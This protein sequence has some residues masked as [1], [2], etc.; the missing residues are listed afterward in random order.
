MV[1]VMPDITILDYQ[2]GNL[3]SIAMAVKYCGGKP[4]I[5]NNPSEIAGA[6][7]LILAGVGAFGDAIETLRKSHLSEAI[8]EFINRGR[9][10]LG[11]C[12]GMQLLFSESYEFGHY[13]GLDLIKGKVIR[14]GQPTETGS[15]FKIPH[16]AWCP[17]Q[18]PKAAE[19]RKNMSKERDIWSNSILQGIDPGTNFYFAHSYMCI[20]ERNADCLAGS[21][22]GL[23]DF[24][25][26][27]RHG[28]IWGCQFHPENS[29]TS[30]LKIYE[31]FIHNID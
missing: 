5:T 14:F 15:R 10:L 8:V 20:P 22:Y 1:N 17:I 23:Q 24:C 7:K 19:A 21:V 29:G 27:V 18:K 12:L 16:I 3:F 4:V 28:N 25:S 6:K 13:H 9:P 26:A 31:N 2:R 30:G 11:I